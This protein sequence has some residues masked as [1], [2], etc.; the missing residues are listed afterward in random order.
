MFGI[1]K[2][3]STTSTKK[4]SPSDKPDNEG[5]LDRRKAHNLGIQ[6]RALGLRSMDICDALLEGEGLSGEILEILVKVA[7]S[8]DERK[9]FL[10]LDGEK[11]A[12]LG[13]AD[14]FISAVLT[15]PN[16]WLRVEAMLCRAQ[17]EEDLPSVRE[18]LETL[19]VACKDLQESRTFRKLLE[20]VLKTGNR[21]NMGTYRGNAQAFK[22]D[23]L[24]KLADIKGVDNK[25]TLLY[26]VV[27]EINKAESANV[28][29]SAG[30]DAS[31]N[32]PLSPEASGSPNISNFPATL[33]AAMK[34]E[35][36]QNPVAYDKMKM[37]MGKVMGLPVELATV[38]KAGGF[39]WHML[40][41]SVQQL[42][43]GFQGIKAQVEE[44]RYST[45]G[46]SGDHPADNFQQTMEEFIAAAEADVTILQQ[47]RREVVQAVKLINIYFHGNENDLEP[48]KVFLIVKEFLLM[49]EKACKDV[50]RNKPE[51]AAVPNYL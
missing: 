18:S 21:L 35:T 36:A 1:Q 34:S 14:R 37:H 44:G 51:P 43:R 3:S 17:Y 6:L 48:L 32:I 45:T 33:E 41:Q 4:P 5:I 23:S 22:L 25:T 27:Q 46:A 30:K 2:T 38:S 20:A 16:A 29:R 15:V 7:P 11:A 19:K 31:S 49:L 47:E 50:L 26:F 28:N 42:V 40:Q 12:R 8:E 39:D 10:E 24:L 13:P 9:K